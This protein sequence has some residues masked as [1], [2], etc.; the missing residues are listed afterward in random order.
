MLFL[1]IGHMIQEFGVAY[2]SITLIN[3][4]LFIFLNSS[5]VILELI[6]ELYNI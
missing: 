1:V 4:E 5:A 3:Y 6:L 2:S